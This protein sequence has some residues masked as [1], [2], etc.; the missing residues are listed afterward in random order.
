VKHD[1]VVSVVLPV[2]PCVKTFD[3]YKLFWVSQHVTHLRT[4]WLEKDSELHVEQTNYSKWLSTQRAQGNLRD[5]V[6]SE[7]V[8]EEEEEEEEDGDE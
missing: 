4:K 2:L 1:S 7:S 8:E 3:V 5:D 6:G